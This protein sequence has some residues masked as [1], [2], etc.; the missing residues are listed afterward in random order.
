MEL[1]Q[2]ELAAVAVVLTAE[3]MVELEQELVE[4]VVVEM[5]V[6]L[7]TPKVPILVMEE[8]V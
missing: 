2:L 8:M 5:V 1:I 4:L 7:H 3:T 6:E